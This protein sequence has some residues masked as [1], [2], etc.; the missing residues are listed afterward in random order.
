MVNPVLI[1]QATTIT[2]Q[3]YVDCILSVAQLHVGVS[4]IA[5]ELSPHAVKIFIFFFLTS[6]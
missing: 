5:Y 3:F 4:S 2:K 1:D 6:A